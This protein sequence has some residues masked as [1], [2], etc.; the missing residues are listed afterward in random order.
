[1]GGKFEPVLPTISSFVN[2]CG[3]QPARTKSP[4]QINFFGMEWM[5]ENVIET[6]KSLSMQNHAKQ[7]LIEVT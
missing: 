5:V 3:A 7:D 4:E 1:L 2:F 6:P